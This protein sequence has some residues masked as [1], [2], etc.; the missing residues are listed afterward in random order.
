M[1]RTDWP[2][3]QPV[4]ATVSVRVHVTHR[5]MCWADLEASLTE[6]KIFARLFRTGFDE[7][8]AD[9]GFQ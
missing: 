2:R 7:H 9:L 4:W 6:G 1:A 5:G 3:R 8:L